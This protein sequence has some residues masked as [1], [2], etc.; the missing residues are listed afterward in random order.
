MINGEYERIT[1]YLSGVGTAEQ[2]RWLPKMTRS[3][4]KGPSAAGIVYLLEPKNEQEPVLVYA[5]GSFHV[6]LTD[7]E[8]VIKA[9]AQAVQELEDVKQRQP[10][11]VVE[12][13]TDPVTAT[14]LRTLRRAP[15]TN[16]DEALN[17]V[18]T[19][20]A[21]L[22][23]GWFSPS[24]LEQNIAGLSTMEKATF[25][26]EVEQ[27]KKE[28]AQGH[29]TAQEVLAQ[30][31]KLADELRT[32]QQFVKRPDVNVLSVAE[33][34]RVLE[35]EGK[36]P[37]FAQ[38][39]LRAANATARLYTSCKDERV[40]KQMLIEQENRIAKTWEQVEQR[41][42][43]PPQAD[44]TTTIDHDHEGASRNTPLSTPRLR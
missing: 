15:L 26:Y 29:R 35:H 1:T 30:F 41:R 32:V 34:R 31:P 33:Y 42:Q 38:E 6:G 28:L 11:C 39:M 22:N 20:I 23:R 43:A 2:L 12:L 21:G 3:E 19:H 36:D 8:A 4:A 27:I 17:K 5:Q 40:L 10:T 37:A 14:M 7:R 13:V 25:E 44:R 24:V 18:A 9:T 16:D